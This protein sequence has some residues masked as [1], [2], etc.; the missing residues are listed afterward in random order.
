VLRNGSHVNGISFPPMGV[1]DDRSLAYD[2]RAIDAVTKDS[3][4][5]LS[6]TTAL[7]PRLMA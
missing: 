4:P 6:K 7:G 5:A 1:S 2:S 3:I